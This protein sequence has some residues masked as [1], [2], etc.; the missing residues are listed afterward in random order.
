MN[1]ILLGAQGS[2]KGTQGALLA[3]RFGLALC[4]RGE[5]LREAISQGTPIGQQVRPYYDRGDLVPDE[6]MVGMILERLTSLRDARG[7]IL[8]GFPRNLAQAQVLD[9]RLAELRHEISQVIYLDVPRDL[10]RERLSGRYICRAY[11]HVY[12]SKTN[13]PKTP[14]ICDIDGSELFQRDDDTGPAIEKRLAIFF[15]ETLPQLKSHYE[16]LGKLVTIDGTQSIDDVTREI[17][18]KLDVSE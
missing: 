17:L 1:L 13:P 5:L 8:D 12:N 16:P 11:G 9:A 3:A 6:L 10:L 7:I 14:G 4:A 15:T 18:T 2:G